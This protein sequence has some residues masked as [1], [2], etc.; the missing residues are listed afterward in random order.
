MV[1]ID[2]ILE[3]RRKQLNDL[4]KKYKFAFRNV[5]LD[6]NMDANTEYSTDRQKHVMEVRSLENQIN[7]VYMNLLKDAGIDESIQT[8]EVQNESEQL[9]QV[10]EKQKK[11]TDLHNQ[12]KKTSYVKNS[13]FVRKEI[14]EFRLNR[15]KVCLASFSSLFLIF[16][17]VF[18]RDIKQVDNILF[19]QNLKTEN[20]I[21]N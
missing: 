18:F 5:R 17:Y 21:D 8:I 3:K 2:N 1:G 11:H 20:T 13:A 9:Q 6:Y 16:C 14:T 7:N 19:T 15:E 10:K 4:L 12:S